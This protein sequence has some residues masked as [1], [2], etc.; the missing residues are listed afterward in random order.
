MI[1]CVVVIEVVEGL[2]DDIKIRGNEHLRSAYLRARIARGI[3]TPVNVY[4]L[5][6]EIDHLPSASRV[7]GCGSDSGRHPIDSP[8]S[9]RRIQKWILVR[10]LVQTMSP[11]LW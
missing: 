11:N 5:E 7:I 10:R 9:N 8:I 1:D 6:C 2:L 3:G 4:A